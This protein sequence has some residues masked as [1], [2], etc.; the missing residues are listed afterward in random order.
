M[1]TKPLPLPT[2]DTAGFFEAVD[3]G[4]LKVPRCRECGDFFLYPRAYCPACMSDQVALE[5][6]SGVAT[7]ESYVVNH[8]AAPGFE[9]EVPYVVALVRLAEGPRLLATVTGAGEAG[10][11]L[12]I[13][14]ELEVV[15]EQRGERKVVEF[16][17]RKDE[18]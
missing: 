14:G 1:S 6:V 4:E 15:F 13:D 18:G 2:P 8:R 7:L 12:V 11:G 5:P 17:P 10:S 16:R 9:G 3:G